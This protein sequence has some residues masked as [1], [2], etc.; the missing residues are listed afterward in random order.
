MHPKTIEAQNVRVAIA[1]AIGLTTSI[2]IGVLVGGSAYI[3][4]GILLISGLLTLYI[5]FLNQS[6]LPIAFLL[7]CLALQVRPA[8]PELEALHISYIAIAIFL[9]ANSWRKDIGSFDNISPKAF[10]EFKILFWIFS[11]YLVLQTSINHFYTFPQQTMSWGNSAKQ[12][13]KMWAAYALIMICL[14]FVRHLIAPKHL[15]RWICTILLIG[16]LFNIA[17][18]AYGVFVLNLH[19]P[20]EIKAETSAGGVIFIPAINLSES[21]Y[22]LRILGPFSVLVGVMIL[23]YRRAIASFSTQII[24][25]SLVIMGIMG[26]LLGGGRASLFMVAIYFA[27]TFI[28]RKFYFGLVVLGAALMLVT[29]ASRIAYEISPEHIPFAIQRSLA[30]IPGMDMP[31]ARGSIEGSTAW[32]KE[33][34]L[35]A[36]NE[37]TS[38]DRKLVFGRG[39]HAWTDKDI[40]AATIDP[41]YQGL[42]SNLQRAT[43]HNLVTDLLLVVG[44]IGAMLYI[45]VY[46]SVFVGAV[47][48]LKRVEDVE[49]RIIL[50]I[51]CLAMIVEFG[52]ALVGGA[53]FSDR[54]AILI[55]LV[56]AKQAVIARNSLSGVGQ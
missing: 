11:I 4:A 39:V 22:V 27:F 47:R 8:G 41:N 28:Y 25:G 17:I 36:I 53:F 48:L 38:G 50:E 44:V 45:L 23:T 26:A 30:M 43:T 20:L 46:W 19:T 21:L 3:P 51:V 54:I 35:A 6:W 18:K 33:L 55:G 34:G 7:A 2:A 1:T 10:R 13:F 49:N 9:A 16:L 40:I 37:W 15:L 31:E 29:I 24:P 12:V 5:V 52:F 32:R 14:L 42:V 56:L